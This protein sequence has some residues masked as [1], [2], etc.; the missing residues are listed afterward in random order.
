MALFLRDEDVR[1]T[2]GMDD[3]LEAIEEMQHHYGLGEASNLGRRKIIAGSGLLSVM[4]GGLYY[5]GVFGVKTYTV[6][7]GRYSFHITLYDTATGHLVAFLQANRLGQLRT[8]A[9]H[10]GDCQISSQGRC[11]GSG[12][13]W[14]WLPGPHPA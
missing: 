13:T 4:G 1:A 7:S 12:H 3:M 5:K 9:T 14:H 8:G 11:G 6:I 2:V 10:R